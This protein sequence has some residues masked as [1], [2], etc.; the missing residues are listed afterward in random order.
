MTGPAPAAAAAPPALRLGFGCGSLGS[1]IGYRDSC[2]LIEAAY[3]AGFRHFD[4]APPYG[5]GMAERILGDVLAPVRQHI[6]LV[7]KAGIAH[8]QNA[9]LLRALR[10]LAL[11]VRRAWPSLWR[12]AAGT[13][14]RVA[15][16]RGQ[17][18]VDTVRASLDESLRRL[19]T[20]YLDALL[21]HEVQPG[22]IDDE[23]ATW[24]LRQRTEGRVKALGIGTGVGASVALLAQHPLLLDWVQTDHYWGAFTPL[25]R[26]DGAMLITHRCLRD[27]WM[28]LQSPKR[29]ASIDRHPSSRLLREALTSP[30]AGAACLLAA[31]LRQ[32][33][34]RKLLVSASSPA[35]VRELVSWAQRA[36]GPWPEAEAVQ[37]LMR[38][39]AAAG[40]TADEHARN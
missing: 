19:R 14:R 9:A 30:A 34:G 31:G 3:E 36:Q 27:G 13:A 33:A 28:L 4:V 10:Q 18:A 16:P 21:L 32:Q 24:L 39:W 5:N 40:S 29:Q 37:D 15:A 23:L 25:L 6:T 38:Q 11:P 7:S 35:R 22:D 17:F 1:E 12:R 8:P 2:A 20:D 26:R